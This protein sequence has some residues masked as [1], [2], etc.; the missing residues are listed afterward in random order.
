MTETFSAVSAYKWLAD[1]ERM[2]SFLKLEF[3]D[4]TA[5]SLYTWLLVLSI[6]ICINKQINTHT[7][8]W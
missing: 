7:R 1:G 3:P 5:S 8:V 4:V 6:I 2:R